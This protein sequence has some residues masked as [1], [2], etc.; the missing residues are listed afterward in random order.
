[1]IK[2]LDIYSANPFDADKEKATGTNGVIVKAGQGHAVY[3]HRH[4]L[5]ECDRV[6]LPWG[7]YWLSD[8]R[9]SPE[10]HKRAVKNTFPDGN[11]GKLGMWIDVEKPLIAMPDMMYRM[12]PYRYAEPIISLING[13][14]EYSGHRP[15]IYTSKG[16]YNLILSGAEVPDR[17]FLGTLPLWTAQYN[18]H[19]TRPDLYGS[20]TTWRYWQFREGPDHSSF[21]G[22]DIKFYE[23]I[24]AIPPLPAGKK[25]SQVINLGESIQRMKEAK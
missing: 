3:K 8:A 22:T 10:G 6:G 7:V 2:I 20:W 15:G 18:P 14:I 17:D 1:M 12:L 25:F 11:F 19:I 21:N 23:M 24:G 4:F 13:I 5:D 16:A 9:Y